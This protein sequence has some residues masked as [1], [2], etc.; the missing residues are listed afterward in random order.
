MPRTRS[1]ALSCSHGIALNL[2][3]RV[4]HA[5]SPA[6]PGH[7]RP[8]GPVV[9]YAPELSEPKP[10]LFS[11]PL[12][13]EHSPLPGPFECGRYGYLPATATAI[14]LTAC[15]L[16]ALAFS[17]RVEE[18][19]P[20]AVPLVNASGLRADDDCPCR[21][22]G[23]PGGALVGTPDHSTK[24]VVDVTTRK[25]VSKKHR[26]LIGCIHPP[27]ETSSLYGLRSVLSKVRTSV[28][29]P[30][31]KYKLPNNS[32]NTG[33]GMGRRGDSSDFLAVL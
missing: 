5:T 28:K 17:I 10:P 29:A 3:V 2:E 1:T 31:H 26:R 18:S 23:L 13:K 20:E 11:E 32:K 21:R 15:L 25:A 14:V 7:K 16:A 33:G 27:S 4:H 9:V 12:P 8:G 6:V 22:G 19:P 24:N 30:E